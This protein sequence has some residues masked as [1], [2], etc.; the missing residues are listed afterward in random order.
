MSETLLSNM[1]TLD[2]WKTNHHHDRHHHAHSKHHGNPRVRR[3]RVMGLG[4]GGGSSGGDGSGGGERRKFMTGDNHRGSSFLSSME[5]DESSFHP[6]SEEAS[7]TSASIMGMIASGSG[8]PGSTVDH[9]VSSQ[10]GGGSSQKNRGRSSSSP[11][12]AR[13]KEQTTEFT[14]ET[15]LDAGAFQTLFLA[16]RVVGKEIINLYSALE[17]VHKSSE[18]YDGDTYDGGDGGVALDDVMRCLGDLP[19]VSKRIARVYEYCIENRPVPTSSSSSKLADHSTSHSYL[20][21][22]ESF[23]E[24][25]DENHDNANVKTNDD[26]DAPPSMRKRAHEYQSKRAVL[27]LVDFFRLF[28][29]KIMRGTPYSTP[30]AESN[31]YLS[32]TDL[33]GIEAHQARIQQM[34]VM[35][36]RV[37]KAAVRISAYVDAMA[38]V[39][40]GWKIP[41]SNIPDYQCARMRLSF[42][43]EDWNLLQDSSTENEYY[44]PILSRE[45]PTAFALVGCNT[46]RLSS[47][48]AK[49]D[50]DPV[51]YIPNLRAVIEK[52]PQSEFFVCG[53]VHKKE[54]LMTIFLFVKWL[55]KGVDEPFDEAFGS[56][57]RG[58]AKLR[59]D[60][61]Y[62]S[63]AYGKCEDCSLCDM[64]YPIPFNFVIDSDHYLLLTC[65]SIHFDS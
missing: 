24:D 53:L 28:V 22:L 48:M 10:K 2:N 32:G 18:A 51:A 49:A 52:H 33:D 39:K 60:S 58:P 15:E 9:F 12:K 56:F 46:F 25:G 55:P 65:Q 14:F 36:Q 31:V 40:E 43:Q 8:V 62:F 6:S 37:A 63:S 44:D 19:F 47:Q 17:L 5:D 7:V 3:R 50:T 13:V 26:E 57:S 27:G 11:N 61:L 30:V 4:M 38:I 20:S 34:V 16:L 35:R 54:R 29:P 45:N 23:R 21:S 59:D 1:V 42:D 41:V 64:T